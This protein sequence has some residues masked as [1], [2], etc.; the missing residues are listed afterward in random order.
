M[1]GGRPTDYTPEL[2]ETICERVALTRTVVEA[3]SLAGMPDP[4][5]VY[6]W[7]IRYPEFRKNY[8]AAL[9]FRAEADNEELRRVAYD[10]ETPSDHKRAI[11]DVLKWQQA[12]ANPKR[13]GDKQTLEHSGTVGVHTLSDEELEKRIRE[14]GGG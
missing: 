7:I 3:L 11:I 4:S 9:S 14:L 2:A 5:T 10:L 6:R 8:E 12:R 13:Y 1:S